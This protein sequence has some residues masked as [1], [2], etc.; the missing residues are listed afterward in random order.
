MKQATLEQLE[1][2]TIDFPFTPK[3]VAGDCCV[4]GY[5]DWWVYSEKPEW[6][7]K[8]WNHE[9]GQFF[10]REQHPISLHTEHAIIEIVEEENEND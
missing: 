4:R 2:N 9:E 8:G 7:G 1:L 10:I 3:Y 5:I 6:N